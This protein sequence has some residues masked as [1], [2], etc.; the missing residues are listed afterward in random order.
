MSAERAELQRFVRGQIAAADLP[1]REHV[2]LAFQMLQQHDFPETVLHFSHALQAMAQKAG[3]PERFNQTMT[4]AFL[5]LVAQRM[6]R[7]AG[8]DFA[9]FAA[10]NPDLFDKALLAR[11]YR[12]GQLGSAL[13]RR[14]FLLPDPPTRNLGDAPSS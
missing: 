7:A 8:E 11:W 5:G 6:E 10:A 14:A 2:R 4:I 12:P 9:A 13:A 1:H 3:R